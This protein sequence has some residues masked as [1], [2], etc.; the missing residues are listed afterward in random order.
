MSGMDPLAAFALQA[1]ANAQAAIE[2]ATLN[3]GSLLTEFQAQLNVGDVLPATVLP[4]QDGNDYISLLG[5]TL[6]AQLP[7]GINPGETIALQVTGF[8]NTAIVVRNLGV[9][10]PEEAPPQAPPLP[11]QS[12]AAPQSA[13]LRSAPQQATPAP[14]QTTPAPR[15]TA[16][17]PLAPPRELFVAASV[18][19]Q[20]TQAAQAA[21]T[22]PGVA[23]PQAVPQAPVEVEA[24]LVATRASTTIGSPAL[25]RSAE[26]LPPAAPPRAAQSSTVPPAV[27]RAA[28]ERPS[29]TPLPVSSQSTLLARLRVPVTPV[30]LAAAKLVETATSNATTAY[31]RLDALLA[32]LPADPRTASLRSTLSFVAEF[33]LRNTRALPEQIASYVS[34]VVTSAESK[35]AQIVRAWTQAETPPDPD[36]LPAQQPLPNVANV[37]ASAA[38]RGVALEHDVKMTLLQFVA[39]PPSGSSPQ[40]I[41]ALR[42]ALTA[43]T[44]VQLNALTPE[45]N[46]VNSI[47]IPLPAYFYN[48]GQPAQLRISRDAPN[49]KNT[50]DADNF[51]IAFVLDT[52]SLGTVAIDVQT[53]GRS[54]SVDVKTETPRSADRFRT[55]LGDLRGRLE[56]LHYRVATMAA[57]LA[58]RP[59]P[60]APPAPAAPPVQTSNVDM[61]A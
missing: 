1:V 24:R 19:P 39:N 31:Q 25:K 41:G 44:A 37:A 40:V 51:H 21:R 12:A 26:S 54:V 32:K 47:T 42:D 35:I 20:S 43:T 52:K 59:K 22:A 7:P 36:E 3:L 13:I 50:L 61:Q 27:V 15:Q 28:V 18:K 34:N 10:A 11:P 56:A 6:P 4:P 29:Q 57:G 9:V 48:G 58:A 16:A 8:T 2:E 33:D 23:R 17:S 53:A 14:Q 49:G 30:T 38:E 5:Q 60:A 46:T 45:N 55:S